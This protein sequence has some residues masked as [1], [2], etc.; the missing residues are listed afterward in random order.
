MNKA[1][2]PKPRTELTLMRNTAKSQDTV[3]GVLMGFAAAE[4]TERVASVLRPA[5]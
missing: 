1:F 2:L 3:A 4:K 5:A